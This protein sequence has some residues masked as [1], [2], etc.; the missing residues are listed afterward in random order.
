L[1]ENPEVFDPERFSPE[2]AEKR[3]HLAWMP[4]GAG[5]H[6]CIGRDLALMQSTLLLAMMV[7]RYTF[8]PTDH[9]PAMS[10]STVLRPQDGI[11]ATL[12][13]RA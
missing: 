1:W 7:Q 2:R 11:W 4:F 10:L 8:A 12:S 9:V 3:H 13:R 6:L 5:Q